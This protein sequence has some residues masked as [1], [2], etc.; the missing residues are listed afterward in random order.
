[1]RG[2]HELDELLATLAARRG[3]AVRAVD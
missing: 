1:V 3:W 2:F